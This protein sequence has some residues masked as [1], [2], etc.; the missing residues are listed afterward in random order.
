MKKHSKKPIKRNCAEL[1]LPAGSLDKLKTAFLYGADAVYCGTPDLSLRTKSDF[2]LEELAEGIK[3]AHGCNKKVYLTLNLFSH[4]KD[5][6]KLPRFLKTIRALKPDGIIISDPG[7]FQYVKKCAPRI[8]LHIS[9]QANVC[10]WLTVDYWKKQGASLCVLGR[11][12]TFK[13]LTEIR[14]KCP[15]VKL[16]VFIHG[17]MCMTYSGRCLLSN[18]L[19]ERGANQGNCSQSCRW[20]YKLKLR[21]KDGNIKE[22]KIDDSN[23]ELFEFLL[24]ENFRPGDFMPIEEDERGAYILNS[25]D[26][27]LMPRL[28]KYLELGI[29]SLKIEG[30]HKTAYYVA[31]T[32]R[33][34]RKAIDDWY[35]SPQTWKPDLYMKELEALQNR[36]YTLAFHEGRL[37][38]LSHNYGNSASF[39]EY[40][41][42]GV[43]QKWDGNDI[44]FEVKNPI[45]TGEIIEFLPPAAWEP[46]CLQLPSFTHAD[47]SKVT[48]KI[49]AGAKNFAIRIPASAFK[50]FAADELRKI[51][52][53][54]TQARKKRKNM[55]NEDMKRLM[56]DRKTFGFE[57]ECSQTYMQIATSVRV[58]K[59]GAL[60]CCGKGCNG[61][62]IFWHD[63]KFA[64]E[65]AKLKRKHSAEKS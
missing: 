46:I 15:R 53:A 23:R 34:Y 1:L 35:K 56:R 20:F 25:K 4:N 48:E 54:L 61:C 37:T 63:P 39:S 7:V 50:N 33:A 58:P 3:F 13:E 31:V 43:I 59:L 44:I 51:L 8:P 9:T 57:A 17:A 60:A 11:E 45:C 65:R 22:L 21:L 29:D 42:A 16:E 32:A 30:R 41:V 10:S 18:F 62:A 64:K 40:E 5:I 2:T 28:D 49:S 47:T 14:K 38:H 19:T 12:V 55:S 24:E 6:P 26:L 52:P 27:C 36:G